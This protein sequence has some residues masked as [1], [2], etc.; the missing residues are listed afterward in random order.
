LSHLFVE[1]LGNKDGESVLIQT[2]NADK[3]KANLAL[4]NNVQ[5]YTYWSGTQP[6]TSAIRPFARAPRH[7]H[8]WA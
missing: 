3:Q 4:F 8:C 5:S 2:G 6:A 1:D 7:S